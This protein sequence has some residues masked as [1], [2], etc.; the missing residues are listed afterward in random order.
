MSATEQQKAPVSP[1][2]PSPVPEEKE[3]NVPKPSSPVKEDSCMEVEDPKLFSD[4]TFYLTNNPS[5]EVMDENGKP[6]LVSV[7]KAIVD[8][9]G[10][11]KE[12]LSEA[13]IVIISPLVVKQTNKIS[14]RYIF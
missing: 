13:S 2:K 12:N 8:N 7:L 3:E 9:G 6:V 10:I 1:P 14:F 11:I 4:E 5:I